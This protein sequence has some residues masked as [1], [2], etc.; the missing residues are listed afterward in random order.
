MFDQITPLILTFNEAPNLARTLAQL[1]WAARIV[2]VDSGSTDDTL[3]ICKKFP[4]VEVITR[5]FDD[6]TSQWNFGL[7]QVRTDW[8]LSLDA[9]YVL[10]DELVA[11]L[12]VLAAADGVAGFS[13]RFTYCIHG[14][15]LRASLYP[16]RTVLFRRNHNRY[17]DDGHTQLLRSDGVVAELHGKILHDDRKPLERWFGEQLKYSAKEAVHL[18]STPAAQLNRADQIRRKIIL[19]PP[20]VLLLTLF[21]KGLI[22][23]GWAGWFYALQRTLA[24]VLLSLRLLEVKLKTIDHRP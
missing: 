9:D 19:A 7:D 2:V 10:T 23:D 14:R 8:V 22:L 17:V 1:T 18:T 4:Q 6:H 21:G 16:P 15:P 11:E 5:P 12:R 3:A 20:L 24:E 13:A